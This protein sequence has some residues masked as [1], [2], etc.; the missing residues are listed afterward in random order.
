ML[1]SYEPI[2]KVPLPESCTALGMSRDQVILR[3]NTGQLEGGQE[4]GRWFVTRRAI[5]AA[6]AQRDSG[7]R[8]A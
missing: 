7:P 1:T 2:E 6:L 4:L 8:A 3:I 5:A